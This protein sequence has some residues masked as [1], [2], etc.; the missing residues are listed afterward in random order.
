MLR[1]AIQ[2]DEVNRILRTLTGV[3]GEDIIPRT[4]GW[5]GWSRKKEARAC[6]VFSTS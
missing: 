3:L 6:S 2:Y 5:T 1:Y 4:D